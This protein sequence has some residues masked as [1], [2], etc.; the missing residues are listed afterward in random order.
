MKRIDAA[1]VLVIVGLAMLAGGLGAFDWRLALVAVGA[2][3][4]F[5]GLAAAAMRR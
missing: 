4:L 3:M 2:V 5:V 1:D